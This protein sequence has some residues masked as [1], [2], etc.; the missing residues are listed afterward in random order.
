[1]P[2]D[3]KNMNS[4]ERATERVRVIFTPWMSGAKFYILFLKLTRVGGWRSG[5]PD[6]EI[7]RK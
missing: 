1:M 7:T 6:R 5:V 4:E 3:E 2:T